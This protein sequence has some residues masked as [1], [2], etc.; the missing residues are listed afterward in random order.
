MLCR[1]GE[2]EMLKSG[3]RLH[4][5]SADMR[6]FTVLYICKVLNTRQGRCVTSVDGHLIVDSSPTK[7][8]ISFGFAHNL[9]YGDICAG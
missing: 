6:M 2:G 9:L 4:V 7:L 1:F 8:W 5:D 3:N